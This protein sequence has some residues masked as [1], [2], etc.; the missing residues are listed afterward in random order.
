MSFES[1]ASAIARH[2]LRHR[3]LRPSPR[4]LASAVA[5]TG[6]TTATTVVAATT[7]D[8]GDSRLDEDRPDARFV[9]RAFSA[10]CKALQMLV[11]TRIT[12]GMTAIET[13]VTA[14]ETVTAVAATDA[15]RRFVLAQC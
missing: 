7:P 10:L 12:A 13:A 9:D 15:N 6:G 3:L 8:A 2:H 5:V 14:I 11:E 1:Q 4:S